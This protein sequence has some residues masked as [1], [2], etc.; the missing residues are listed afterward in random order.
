MRGVAIAAFVFALP[1]IGLHVYA[2]NYL[3]PPAEQAEECKSKSYPGARTGGVVP[4]TAG[5]ISQ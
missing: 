3:E 4:L 5:P 1:L 2:R